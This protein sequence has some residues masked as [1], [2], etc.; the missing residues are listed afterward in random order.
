VA[1]GVSNPPF[2]ER[3]GMAIPAPP[4]VSA[5]AASIGLYILNPVGIY[6]LG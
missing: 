4:H 1:T 2:G 3:G 6:I 5:L